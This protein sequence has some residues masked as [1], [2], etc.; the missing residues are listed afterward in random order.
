MANNIEKFYAPKSIQKHVLEEGIDDYKEQKTEEALEMSKKADEIIDS[1]YAEGLERGIGNHDFALSKKLA[2]YPKEIKIAIFRRWFKRKPYEVLQQMDEFG[3][4]PSYFQKN[5]AEFL[6]NHE[7]PP[8]WVYYKI[9]RVFDKITDR[10]LHQFI[11][12]NDHI[13][14]SI[15][16]ENKE[17]LP[18]I[19]DEQILKRADHDYEKSGSYSSNSWY[20]WATV[21][22]YIDKFP[23]VDKQQAIEGV[24]NQTTNSNIGVLIEYKEKL[25]LSEQELITIFNQRKKTHELLN[26]AEYIDPR[27]HQEIVDK[28]LESTEVSYYHLW[29]NSNKLRN[30]DIKKIWQKRENDKNATKFGIQDIVNDFDYFPTEWLTEIPQEY[31]NLLCFNHPEII[32]ERADEFRGKLDK[33]ELINTLFEKKQFNI[34]ISTAEKLGQKRNEA[35]ANRIIDAGGELVVIHGLDNF[36]KMSRQTYLRIFAREPQE[37]ANHFLSFEGITKEDIYQALDQTQASRYSSFVYSCITNHAQVEGLNLNQEFAD[38]LAGAGFGS[39]LIINLEKFEGIDFVA[40]A[41]KLITKHH[42]LAYLI[43]KNINLFN[44]IAENRELGEM[45]WKESLKEDW[46][47]NIMTRLNE[48]YLPPID[49][50]FTLAYDM[51]GDHLTP[52]T[53]IIIAALKNG[54]ITNEKLKTLGITRTGETGINQLRQQLTKFK[55]KIVC[56]DFD[57]SVLENSDF[58]CQYYKSYVRYTEGDWGDKDERSFGQIIRTHNRLKHEGRLRELPKEYVESDEIKIAMVDRKKQEAFQYS[59]QFLSY[60]GTLRESITKALELSDQNR[61]LL[62]LVEIIE[63]KRAEILQAFKDK[64]AQL[65][66][67]KADENLQKNIEMLKGLNLRNIKNFQSNFETLSQFSELREELRQLVFY[68]ALQKKKNYREAAKEITQQEKPRFDDVRWMINFIERVVNEETWA[69]YFT[70][71]RAKKSFRKLFNVNVLNEEFSRAQN[72]TSLKSS[73]T[74]SMEFEFI[75]TRG[76]LMEF[77]GHIADACWASKYDSIAESFPNFS[78]IVLVRNRGTKNERLVGASMLIETT[79]QDGTPLLVIRGLN[80]IEN[81]INSLNVEDFYQKFTD[82]IAQIAKKT[83][84]EPAIVIDDHSGGSATNRPALFQLLCE[85]KKTLQGVKLASEKDT[86]FNDYNIVNCT[87]IIE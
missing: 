8:S 27:Y 1:F 60:F 72:Q 48:M 57:T 79:A 80:P 31:I 4:L 53:Y 41:E 64:P 71:D 87:Y 38:R 69:K 59:K 2:Q 82:Y 56:A 25:G 49:Q 39:D 17:K 50:T 61:P 77:S 9:L 13:N 62:H 42:N 84:R 78:T 35:F 10:N 55:S 44:K 45:I 16:A 28:C 65:Q 5:I 37:T 22:P 70:D 73:E 12:N 51:L 32:A 6:A 67:S 11:V 18:Y 74:T 75:P 43:A 3:S 63:T 26:N 7:Q 19:S 36:P 30:V 24:F 54:S 20:D 81:V 21:I 85:K 15:L 47:A 46:A 23:L 68:Y 66:H 52:D 83:G 34:L 40:L 58:Y 33:E 76:L 29:K 14:F 86:S